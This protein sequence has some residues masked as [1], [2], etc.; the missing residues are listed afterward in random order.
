[1]PNAIVRFDD[2]G[3]AVLMALEDIEAGQEVTIGYLDSAQTTLERKKQLL[4]NYYFNCECLQC[5]LPSDEDQAPYSTISRKCQKE[6][7][8]RIYKTVDFSNLYSH[9]SNAYNELRQQAKVKVKGY[10]QCKNRCYR[11][12][13]SEILK[14]STSDFHDLAA[15]NG[16]EAAQDSAEFIAA[17]YLL[18]YPRRHN[19]V[20]DQIWTTSKCMWNA[21]IMGGGTKATSQMVQLAIE[22]VGHFEP[23]ETELEQLIAST[24]ALLTTCNAECFL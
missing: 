3:H 4:E 21:Q 5:V 14:R 1:M 16:W 23:E 12:S 22:G 6:F 7:T 8:L 11:N 10:Y 20:W 24:K 9:T 19:L 18:I 2:M 15:V 17:V 13:I